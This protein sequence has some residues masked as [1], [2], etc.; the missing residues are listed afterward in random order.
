VAGVPT[1]VVAAVTPEALLGM[2][3]GLALAADAWTSSLETHP[4]ARTGLRI[5]ATERYDAWLLW[6]PAGTAVSPHHHGDSEAAFAVSSGALRETRWLGGRREERLLTHGQGT[7]VGRRVVHDVAAVVEALS[8]HVYSPPLAR[9][10]FFDDQAENLLLEEPVDPADSAVAVSGFFHVE[11]RGGLDTVLERARERISPRMHP[12]D[13]AAAMDLGALVVD[14][15]PAVLRQRDGELEG[16]LVIDRNVLEWRLDPYGSH[17][18][19][20]ASDADRLVILVCDEGYASSLAAV[21]LLGLGRRNVTDLE[22]GYQAWRRL[23]QRERVG[24]S[25][26]DEVRSRRGRFAGFRPYRV[27]TTTRPTSSQRTVSADAPS[28]QLKP[29]VESR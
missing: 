4:D 20:G 1:Q 2:A 13:L 19:Q 15:R 29:R 24:G 7:T 27:S 23:T 22:G 5:L 28:S 17:R 16:A 21:S 26:T 9:M 6:W 25:R 14:T 12:R 8:V 18:I 11:H 10:A 3:S